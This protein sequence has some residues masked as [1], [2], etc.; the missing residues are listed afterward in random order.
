MANLI[1]IFKAA[2]TFINSKFF[3]YAIAIVF[4]LFLA[5][6]CKNNKDLREEL[7][8]QAQNYSAKN[9]T[10][11][12][13]RLKTGELQFTIDGYIGTIKEL[14][15]YN[16]GLVKE[17]K[18]QK[19]DVIN[20]N[21]IVILL[22]QDK[23]DLRKY[24]DSLKT[25]MKTPI[26][27]NDTTYIVPWTLAFT[28][29]ST[30]FDIWSGQT[31]VGLT[32]AKY[33]A[34]PKGFLLEDGKTFALPKIDF[35]KITLTNLGTEMTSRQT[36]IELVWG[37]KWEKGKLRVFANSKYPG[38]N[39]VNMEGLI[40]EAPKRPHWFTGWSVNFGI[41]PTYD[42]IQA[43]PTIVIGPSV[44]YTIYQF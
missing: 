3:G 11:K 32:A 12:I 39:V 13:E 8:H 15:K 16:S 28:Y 18:K 40:I 25:I 41:M 38:F 21:R 29:D 33:S 30:N 31:K 23:L 19:G 5:Q 43:K 9:D 4:I 20:L 35:S 36:Q 42:F 27:I 26:K 22:E 24:I 7:S 6:M 14:E 44:G 34:F 10:L 1:K 2:W 37:Q 17:V